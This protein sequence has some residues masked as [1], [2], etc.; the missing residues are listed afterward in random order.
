MG[1]L[2]SATTNVT[3]K[4]TLRIPTHASGEHNR[5]HLALSHSLS[6]NVTFVGTHDPT[7]S[8]STIVSPSTSVT[9]SCF[10]AKQYRSRYESGL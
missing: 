3:Y 2:H 8:E 10:E 4:Y 7:Q 6:S 1:T 5:C 9:S